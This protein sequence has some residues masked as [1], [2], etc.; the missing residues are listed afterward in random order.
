MATVLGW[1]GLGIIIG[2]VAVVFAAVWL[3][4]NVERDTERTRARAAARLAQLEA[5]NRILR[6]PDAHDA[7]LLAAIR[8]QPQV[9]MAVAD[10]EQVSA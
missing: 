7:A 5:D 9:T 8:P 4:S 1:I 3:G 6:N 10:G 2:V